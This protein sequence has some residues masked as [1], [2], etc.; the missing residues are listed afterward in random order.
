MTETCK[1]RGCLQDAPHPFIDLDM[2]KYID[3]E[4]LREKIEKTYESE[5]QPWLSGVSP[6]SVIYE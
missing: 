1:V 6:K 4:L 3:A 2:G 5:I